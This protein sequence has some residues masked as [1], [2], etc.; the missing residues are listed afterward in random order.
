MSSQNTTLTVLSGYPGVGKSFVGS[1]I[2]AMESGLMFNTDRVRKDLTDGDP[3]Y[4]R[5]ESD[6]TYNEMLKR[7]RNALQDDTPVVLD[8]TFSHRERRDQAEALTDELDIPFR[9]IN[10]VCDEETTKQRIRQRDNFSDADVAVY[11]E[12]KADF[13]DFE[14][15]VITIDNSGGKAATEAQLAKIL[16]SSPEQTV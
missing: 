9:L 8:G 5:D 13:D 6:A 16:V 11:Q 10:V 2:A 4:S 12:I 3:T 1:Q 14:R 7:A 15:D